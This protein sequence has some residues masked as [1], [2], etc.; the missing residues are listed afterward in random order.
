MK[1]PLEIAGVFIATCNGKN[2]RVVPVE[3]R[4]E[5]CSISSVCSVLLIVRKIVCD[6]VTDVCRQVLRAEH[7]A[8]RWRGIRTARPAGGSCKNGFGAGRQ[9]G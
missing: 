4:W 6:R 3:S 1:P 2:A 7:S 5:Y 8:S 9:R